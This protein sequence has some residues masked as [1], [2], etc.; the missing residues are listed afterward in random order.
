MWN[1][2]LDARAPRRLA[3]LRG[4]GLGQRRL[5][6]RLTSTTDNFD[7]TGGDGGV[8]PDISGDTLCTSGNCDPTPGGTG[9]YFNVSAFSR[10]AGRAT[11]ATRR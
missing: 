10:L 8:R 2:W 7:F 6:R 1:N 4:Y 3:A 5:V 9:S 11:S